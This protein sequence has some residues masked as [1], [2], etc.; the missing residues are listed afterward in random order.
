MSQ[1]LY[2][3]IQRPTKANSLGLGI[4]WAIQT[5]YGGE[6]ST[7]TEADIPF[8]KGVRAASRQDDEM[9]RDCQ[10]LIEAIETHGSVNVW[11]GE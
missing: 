9:K 1:K 3:E 10:T 5:E 8:L 4:K 2:W 7:L 11:I 6:S